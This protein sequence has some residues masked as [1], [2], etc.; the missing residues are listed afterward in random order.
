MNRLDRTHGQMDGTLSAVVLAHDHR[1]RTISNTQVVISIRRFAI[2][3]A[4][5]RRPN[6]DHTANHAPTDA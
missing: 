1:S 3:V 4:E 5:V 2:D 6:I